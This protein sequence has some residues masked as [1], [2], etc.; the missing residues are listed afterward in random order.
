MSDIAHTSSPQPASAGVEQVGRSWRERTAAA[1]QAGGLLAVII[2][3]AIYF[4]VSNPVFLHFTNV[5]EVLR[6][7]VLYFIVAA[8]STLVIVGG[9]LDLSVGALYAAG[10][11]FACDF[12]VIGVPWPVAL[13][14]GVLSGAALGAL[15]ACMAI[16]LKVPPLIA[17]L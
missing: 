9:G 16:Y 17:T 13:V 12:M 7:G 14:L 6:S 4:E 1:T 15:N 10:G 8:G 11:V 3:V 2:A 5:V